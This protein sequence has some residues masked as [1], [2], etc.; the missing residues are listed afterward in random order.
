[1]AIAETNTGVTEKTARA[2]LHSTENPKVY[3]E[4]IVLPHWTKV[5]I[6]S[7]NPSCS[8]SISLQKDGPYPHYIV[9]LL[10]LGTSTKYELKM[11]HHN[12]FATKVLNI[13]LF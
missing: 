6:L 8:R 9:S 2:S 7:P 1:M 13:L 11:Q 5:A 12:E 10:S 3:P 4:I